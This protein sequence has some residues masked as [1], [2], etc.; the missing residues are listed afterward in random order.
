MIPMALEQTWR[1]FGPNDPVSLAEVKQTGV[2]GIVSALHHLPTGSLWPVDEILK[3]KKEIE[4]SG[5]TW[6]VAESVPV[7]EDIKKRSGNY[8]KFVELYQQA[9]RN[10]GLC[11]I[12]TVCY[13]FMPLLDWSRTDLD[14]QLADG[15]VTTRFQSTVFAAFDLC[16]LQ[17]QNAEED[18]SEDQVRE[19]RLYFDK[20]NEAEKRKLLETILLGFPGSLESYSLAELKSALLEYQDLNKNDL[21]DNLR[22]FIR[23]ITPVAEESGVLLAIH[24]DDPPWPLLGLPRIVSNRQDI[25]RL[26]SAADSPSN[27]LTLCTGSLGA[28]ANNDLVDITSTF[29]ARI[30]FVHLRNVVRSGPHDFSES[31]HLDGNVDMHGVM[32]ALLLEQQRR[33]A[34]GR[35]DRRM[36]F[37]PDHGR[38]MFADKLMADLKGQS[39]YPGYSLFG[40]MRAVAELRGLEL[41]IR[42][43]LDL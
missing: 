25:E 11:G 20:L 42:R 10:L 19:A 22:S 5:L 41:G 33:G 35:K 16:V 17:R 34:E 30:N 39:V 24:P 4:G 21:H 29:A 1:W 27:G 13:N 18:Y 15:S 8:H 3:R 2:S 36:P 32:K 40:R 9:I 6:S 14:V 31:D 12:D 26:L 37:R 28:S 43:S 23:E 7:H 38:L